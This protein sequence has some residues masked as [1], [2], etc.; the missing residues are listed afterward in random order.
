MFGLVITVAGTFGIADEV[1]SARVTGHVTTYT[2]PMLD[3]A[4]DGVGPTPI[5]AHPTHFPR[6]RKWEPGMSVELVCSELKE[7]TYSCDV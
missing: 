5:T 2:A 4:I 6:G 3:V 7:G 1:R